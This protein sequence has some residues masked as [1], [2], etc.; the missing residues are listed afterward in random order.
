M[1]LTHHAAVRLQQRAIPPFMIELIERFGSEIRCDGA[2]R[3]FFDK[4]ARKAHVRPSLPSS[5]RAVAERLSRNRR[6][7]PPSYGSSSLEA[8]QYTI[9]TQKYTLE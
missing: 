5:R 3:L 1:S 6:Q 2:S 7:W 9:T 8:I 4:A